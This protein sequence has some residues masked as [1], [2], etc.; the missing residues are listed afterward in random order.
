MTDFTSL[1][2]RHV[3]ATLIAS[4]DTS[5]NTDVMDR[6]EADAKS[7]LFSSPVLDRLRTSD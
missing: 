7:V 1:L 5:S 2:D 6:D 3:D 4:G